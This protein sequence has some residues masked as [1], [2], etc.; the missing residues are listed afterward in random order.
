MADIDVVV[1]AATE[2]DLGAIIDI[3]N[4]YV[5][6]SHATFD[7][8]SKDM[9][10]GRGWLAAH[11]SGQHRA[12][13][14][15][16]DVRVAGFASSGPY[17]DRAAYHRTVETNAYIAPDLLGRGIGVALYAVLL[18]GLVQEGIHRVVS[19]IAQ[20]NEASVSLHRRLEFRSVA[21]FSEVGWKFGQFWDV[22]WY[23]RSVG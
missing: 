7:I 10:W 20:P 21:H 12:L 22:D 18:E 1:R 8:E 16:A 23:E 9:R 14:A 19:A 2:D 6:T 3:Y 11:T 15:V 4:H 5:A 17:R 13:V